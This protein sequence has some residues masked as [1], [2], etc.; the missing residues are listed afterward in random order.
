MSNAEVGAVTVSHVLG[1][2]LKEL[3][4]AAGAP[5][6]WFRVRAGRDP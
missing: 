1:V 4:Q 6:R 2:G 3:T 5:G